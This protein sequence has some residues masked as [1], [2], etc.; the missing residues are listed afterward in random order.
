M[1]WFIDTA[2]AAPIQ[3]EEQIDLALK[4]TRL[5]DRFRDQLNARQLQIL[6][7]MLDL[8]PTL[9]P[10]DH[11]RPFLVQL[12][13]AGVQTFDVSLGSMECGIPLL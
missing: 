12:S 4:K 13:P 2:L 9:W 11:L 6:L 3:T 10:T 1:S 8:L 5:F 7:R